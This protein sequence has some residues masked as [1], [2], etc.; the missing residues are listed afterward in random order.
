MTGGVCLVIYSW[1]PGGL[2]PGVLSS[3]RLRYFPTKTTA[4]AHTQTMS[5]ESMQCEYEVCRISCILIC[6][7]SECITYHIL[8][9]EDSYS[10]CPFCFFPESPV[11]TTPRAEL[12]RCM[13]SSIIW[14]APTLYWCGVAGH[15]VERRNGKRGSTS[16]L[17]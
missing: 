17:V 15:V 10:T 9:H 13:M 2:C 6:N 3:G 12:G 14:T 11:G 5:C 1:Q 16:P 7:S 8:P 4:H